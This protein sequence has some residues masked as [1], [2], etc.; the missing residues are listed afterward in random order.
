MEEKNYLSF[1]LGNT[2]I[3]STNYDAANTAT[4]DLNTKVKR[5]EENERN[6]KKFTLSSYSNEQDV[7]EIEYCF[8]VKLN[9]FNINLI[10]NM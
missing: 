5:N 10:R 8:N 9:Y 2:A 1:E 4:T 6:E 7:H 3:H